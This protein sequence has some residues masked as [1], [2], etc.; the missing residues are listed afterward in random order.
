MEFIVLDLVQS[1]ISS[2]RRLRGPHPLRIA[3]TVVQNPRDL[4][5]MSS[6]QYTLSPRGDQFIPVVPNCL[7]FR[8]CMNDYQSRPTY[9]RD[10]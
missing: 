2:A 3:R 10:D 8:A 1:E 7:Y 5:P 4:W 6:N 9:P